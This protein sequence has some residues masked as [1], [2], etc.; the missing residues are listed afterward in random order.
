[1]KI[2]YTPYKKDYSGACDRRRFP[3][4]ARQAGLEFETYRPGQAYDLVVVTLNSDLSALSRLGPEAKKVLFD[5]P[6]SYL[7]SNA[8][9]PT[10]LVKASQKY[11]S[12]QWSSWELSFLRVVQRMC[13]RANAIACSTPEQ[14]QQLQR[15]N[16]NTHAIL[17]FH[18]QE[19]DFRKSDYRAHQPLRLVWE[20]VG[21][22]LFGFEE[23]A[24]ALS[25]VNREIPLELHLFTDLEFRPMN[26]FRHLQAKKIMSQILPEVRFYLYEWNASMLAAVA[27]QCDLALIPVAR[28]KPM[29]RAKPENRQLLFWRMGVPVV[30][31]STPAYDRVAAKAGLKATFDTS[32]DWLEGLRAYAAQ[33]DLRRHNAQAGAIYVAD[34]ASDEILRHRWE[35]LFETLELT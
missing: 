29:N 1:M 6:D 25:Q 21:D 12:K 34:Q 19:L 8:W 17:D 2:G 33:E 10:N 26:H 18:S 23:V 13:R 30:T 27:T 9:H 14:H 28:K 3:N 4:F 20:G 16:P 24:D 31:S 11:F 7:S 35:R 15:L 32:A 22:S 5:L